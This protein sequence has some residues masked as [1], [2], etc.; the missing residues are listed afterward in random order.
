[1][2]V[3]SNESGQGTSHADPTLP[4]AAPSSCVSAAS[5]S[6]AIGQLPS[7]VLHV[8]ESYE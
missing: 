1:M 7:E 6:V 5:V 2:S 4:T 3:I 8:D